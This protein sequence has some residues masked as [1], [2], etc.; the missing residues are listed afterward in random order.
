VPDCLN[1]DACVLADTKNM[2]NLIVTQQIKT[3]KVSV[4]KL[5]TCILSNT[6]NKA[7]QLSDCLNLA[8]AYWWILR[9]F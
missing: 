7:G 9:K 5:D 2:L 8:D 3:G 4:L 1:L 6:I